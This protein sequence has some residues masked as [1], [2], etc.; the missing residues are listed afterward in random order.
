M[1][2]I[3]KVHQ[4]F[5]EAG[6]NPKAIKIKVVHSDMELKATRKAT[7]QEQEAVAKI[8]RENN[9]TFLKE[10]CHKK[11]P[12]AI[13]DKKKAIEKY[14]ASLNENSYP[15]QQEKLHRMK[16]RLVEYELNHESLVKK[17]KY[18]EE[19]DHKAVRDEVEFQKNFCS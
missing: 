10:M 11:M 2:E 17:L 14:E 12:A 8:A 7:I 9:L 19:A 3:S 16:T 5:E 13:N 1:E 4:E 18:L 15:E 6:F